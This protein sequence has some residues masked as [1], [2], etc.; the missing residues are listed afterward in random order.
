[1]MEQP[2]M[3]GG[4]AQQPSEAAATRTGEAPCATCGGVATT[5]HEHAAGPAYIFALGRIEPRFPSLALE[6]EFAQ[7]TGQ[8]QTIGLS[9]PEALQAV[10]VQ[11][12]NRYLARELCW[13]L[14]IAGL[15]AY[16]VTPR[17][18]ADLDLLIESVRPAPRAS[19]VDVVIGV[20]GPM[21]P[22]SLCNGL[23]VP[24]VAFDQLYSFDVD[25]LIA[26]IPRPEAVS[27][28]RFQPA[29]E[30]LFMRIM[31]LAAN[32]G[33][34][35]EHR[36]LN[37]LAVRYPAIYATTADAHARDASLSGVEVLRSGLSGSR[38]IMDVIFSYTSRATEITEKYFV[39]VDVTE[40][41][42]F[43]VSRMSPYYGR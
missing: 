8:S 17:D 43:I 37:Y 38:H 39:R 40:E 1:M 3:R 42:P 13:V 6:K 33:A 35:H 41:F 27:A 25:T 2:G 19:D 16:I 9:D 18:P 11:R 24:L 5:H 14:T 32:T 34:T 4:P 23:I 22:P 12:Q 21:A 30:A 29:A 20:R 10:L 15:E 26:G 36:A 31:Q 7:A 28:E